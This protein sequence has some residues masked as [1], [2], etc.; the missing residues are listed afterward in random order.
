MILLNA[1]QTPPPLW[2][3]VPFVSLL[4]M[5]ATGP[6]FFSNVW[7]HYYKH[8]SLGLG[9]LVA[10]YYL[11]VF[12]EPVLVGESFAEY[13]S[14]ISLLLAL[15][16]ASGGIYI[17]ADIESKVWVN[18]GFLLIGAVITNLIGTT[19]A[20]VLLIRPFMRINRYRLQPYHIIF[21]IFFI[22]NLG[23]LLTPIGDPPLFM[24]FLKG[25]PFFWTMQHLFIEWLLAMVLLSIAFYFYDKRNTKLDDVDVSQHYTNR[26]IVNG[27][28]NFIWLALIIGTVFLDP[29]TI[30]GFPAIELHGRKISYIREILQLSIAFACYRFASKKALQS[31]SFDFEP[32]KEVA[33]LFIGIF[34]SMIPALQ[35]LSGLG[36]E[37]AAFSESF[38]YW[39][40]GIF[41]SVLDNAPTYVNF[42]TL[43]LSS[44]GF[45]AQSVKS[46]KDFLAS[47]HVHYLM[48]VSTGSVF[49]GA[50]TY[51]GNGPNFMVKAIAE[52][53]GVKMPSFFEYIYKYSLPILLPILTI[54]WLVFYW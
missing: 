6:L 52:H 1:M 29:N 30:D 21:F 3:V 42:F 32:I 27:K 43:T 5:I 18:I 13:V 12:K 50:M 28:R 48:A 46:V 4:L 20:S 14:F 37:G 39:G 36:S 38:M 53:S 33:F 34:M 54:V 8:I 44:F 16:V 19:G 45:D 7:H 24:G 23:G 49:F 25:V 26:I 17:F 40:S 22:S 47:E 35:L 41:S 10:I 9:A 31:N 11:V 15:F 51:I 2:L